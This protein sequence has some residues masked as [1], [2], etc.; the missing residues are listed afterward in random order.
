MSPNEVASVFLRYSAGRLWSWA[1]SC[2]LPSKH[3]LASP[4]L[5]LTSRGKAHPR[6]LSQRSALAAFEGARQLRR[7]W[8]FEE[9]FACAASCDAGE[10]PSSRAFHS[11]AA[12]KRRF[13]LTWANRPVRPKQVGLLIQASACR[14]PPPKLNKH[15]KGEARLSQCFDRVA[16]PQPSCGNSLWQAVGGGEASVLWLLHMHTWHFFPL[17]T[18]HIIDGNEFSV[19]S[20]QI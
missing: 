5:Y 17:F 20:C 14:Q 6:P 3:P 15:S 2:C 8:Y 12:R 7:F 18:S 10:L 16:D 1:K 9:V 13:S 19:C 4:G 11:G